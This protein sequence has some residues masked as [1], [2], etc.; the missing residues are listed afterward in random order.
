MSF[1]FGSSPNESNR[2]I[3]FHPVPFATVA[4]RDHVSAIIGNC[5]HSLDDMYIDM[6]ENLA[7]YTGYKSFIEVGRPT[8]RQSNSSLC[9]SDRKYIRPSV[10]QDVEGNFFLILQSSLYF[11]QVPVEICS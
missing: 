8:S 10:G 5:S 1:P 9:N 2:S 3:V 6:P 4:I 11:Q 7:D